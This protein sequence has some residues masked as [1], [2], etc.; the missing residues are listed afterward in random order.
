MLSHDSNRRSVPGIPG[1]AEA[2][3]R[4]AFDR[5]KS[6]K[7]DILPKGSKV[8]QNNV[9]REA[10]CDPTALKKDRFPVLVKEIQGW[11]KVAG[12]KA[13]KSPRQKALAQRSRN[14]NL[15]KTIAKLKRQRDRAASKLL[16]ANMK[17]LDLTFEIA[18]LNALQPESK[19]TPFKGR[20]RN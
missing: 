7:P 10:N 16:E 20:D 8:S 12:S 4:D 17:I 6:G 13:P 1:R 11:I 14:R 9:A 2:S 5:L 15:R 19:V 3:F 18:R